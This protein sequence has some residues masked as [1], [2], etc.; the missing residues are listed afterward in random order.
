MNVKHKISISILL[1]SLLIGCSEP[2]N[3]EITLA[4]NIDQLII[5]KE[6]LSEECGENIPKSCEQMQALVNV[7]DASVVQGISAPSYAKDIYRK[8]VMS[9]HSSYNVNGKR[10]SIKIATEE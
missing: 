6:K 5:L 3:T 2:N 9:H 4:K 1:A 8:W 7:I 10:K